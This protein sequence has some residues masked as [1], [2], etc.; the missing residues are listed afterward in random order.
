M[1]NTATSYKIRGIAP[2][3]LAEQ[4]PAIR[5][6]YWQWVVDYGLKRKDKELAAGLDKDGKPLRPI[7]AQT[8]KYRR[9]AMT[10][11]GKGSPSAPPLM[12]A[13]QLSRTRSLLAGRALTTHAEF[14]W[15]F[16]AFTGDSWGAVLAF[17]AASGRDVFGLSP[18]GVA[19][20]KAQALRR[21]EAYRAGIR[22][23]VA[24]KV[25]I[26]QAPSIPRVGTPPTQHATFGIGAKGREA[27][28]QGRFT[29]GMSAAQW[30]AYFRQ[31]ARVRI[32]GRPGTS[33]NRLLGAIWGFLGRKRA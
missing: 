5:K 11:S 30:A 15:R 16:D 14:Y 8:R 6:M 1:N 3:G 13:Y 21:W 33:Y 4:P 12:S 18:A 32:P 7:T 9:S 20:V 26:R 29:G 10:P 23:A 22:P 19:W 2:P 24:A 17:Q 28:A 25:P 27:I 31:P